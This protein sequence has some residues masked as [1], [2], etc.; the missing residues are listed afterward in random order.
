MRFFAKVYEA[1]KKI[2]RGRVATYGQIA[3]LCGTARAARQV[4]YALS[5]LFADSKVPWQRVVNRE[6]MISIENL[7][8]P[9]EEQ[10]RRL[11]AEGVKVEL[12]DGNYWVDLEKFLWQPKN[13]PLP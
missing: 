7:K 13:I 6:G 1:V 11:Q 2:P 12:R 8:V 5:K 9:K 3:A 4:G 10:V